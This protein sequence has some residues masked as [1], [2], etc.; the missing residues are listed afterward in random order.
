[1]IDLLRANLEALARGSGGGEVPKSKRLVGWKE[2][3][4]VSVEHGGPGSENKLRA[5]CRKR[6][7]PVGVWRGMAAVADEARFRLWLDGLRVPI[8][9]EPVGAG[10]KGRKLSGAPKKK[11]ASAPG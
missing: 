9:L 1:L 7:A 2:L 5:L 3:L 4:A 11:R 10:G 8:G 6:G